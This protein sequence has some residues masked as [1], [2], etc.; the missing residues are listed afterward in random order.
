MSDFFFDAETN[1][2]VAGNK[3][4]DKLEWKA[5]N[6]KFYTEHFGVTCSFDHNKHDNQK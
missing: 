5:R 1:T 2:A 6:N 3:D 4:S